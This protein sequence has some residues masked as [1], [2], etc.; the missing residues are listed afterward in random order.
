[1]KESDNRE[2]GIASPEELNEKLQH[3]SVWTWLV[4]GISFL[5]LGGVFGW[6]AFGTVEMKAYGTADLVSGVATLHLDEK[7]ASK[8]A[9]GQCVYIEGK[10][11]EIYD[12][13]SLPLAKQFDLP[14][15]E[16]SF[17]VVVKQMKPIEFLWGK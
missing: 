9:V 12:V 3:S 11:G 7:D 6:A 10:Q 5:L 13:S 8:V 2:T 16:Y 14:D 17:Y 4:L 15:Q 1:M